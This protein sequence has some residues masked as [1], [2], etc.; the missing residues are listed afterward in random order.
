M[1]NFSCLWRRGRPLLLRHPAPSGAAPPRLT[2]SRL[3]I[4]L[5]PVEP[6]GVNVA[7]VAAQLLFICRLAICVG[8]LRWFVIQKQTDG[9]SIAVRHLIRQI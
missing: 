7:F 8:V 9:A 6:R 1:P 5:R 3:P 4:W 2:S